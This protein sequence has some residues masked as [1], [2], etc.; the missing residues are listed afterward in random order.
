MVWPQGLWPVGELHGAESLAARPGA[1]ERSVA[2]WMPVL[3]QDDMLVT[4]DQAVDHRHDRA[5]SGNGQRTAVAE[6]VLHVDHDQRLIGHTLRSVM[7]RN[8]SALLFG[9]EC[10]DP[11]AERAGLNGAAQAAHDVLVVLQI[12]PRE[13]HGGENLLGSD[14]VMQVGPAVIAAGGA[15][16][17]LV[18]WPR[19]VAVA[20]IAQVELAAA[21]ESLGRAAAARGQHA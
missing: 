17:L 14:E 9:F 16:A 21:R 4:A 1:G 8:V 7:W 20:R 10:G 11:V 13:Q 18:D 15:G 2:R 6:V 12:V 3:G 19:I 5:G